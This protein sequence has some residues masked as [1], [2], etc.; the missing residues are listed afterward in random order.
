MNIDQYIK[1]KGDCDMTHR[2]EN[3][4]RIGY[5][6]ALYREQLTQ[7]E[8]KFPD[9]QLTVDDDGITLRTDSRE[10]TLSFISIFSGTYKKSLEDYQKDAIRYDQELPD[11]FGRGSEY[12][13]YKFNLSIRS[14][15]PPPSCQIVEYEEAVPAS[16]VK[17]R[18]IVCPVDEAIETKSVPQQEL[19]AV[20]A[21]ENA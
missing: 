9:K 17:K 7:W 12:T 19:E 21:A 8:E 5:V 13:T 18:K 2:M 10:Q 14:A 16:V 15:A 11:L 1:A 6:L 4:I 3:C 20:E